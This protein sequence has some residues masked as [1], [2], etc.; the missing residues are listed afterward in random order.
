MLSLKG[1]E[2]DKLWGMKQWANAYLTKPIEPI[3]LL[4]KV[5]KQLQQGAS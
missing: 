2:S 1:N 4:L 3:D 5:K